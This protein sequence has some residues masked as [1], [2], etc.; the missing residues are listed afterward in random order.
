MF[1]FIKKNKSKHSAKP[2]L[3]KDKLSQ[4]RRRLGAGLG[5]L[6]LGKKQIDDDLLEELET[7]LL[8]ADVGINTTDKV[9]TRCAKMPHAKH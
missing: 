3:L 2:G 1:N 5:A 6:L 9:C 4:S 7:L 8:T